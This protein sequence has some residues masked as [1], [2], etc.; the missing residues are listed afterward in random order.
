MSY[1]TL[2]ASGGDLIRGKATDGN[3]NS[4]LKVSNTAGEE[5]RFVQTPFNELLL[6]QV[7]SG[8]VV[9]S[10]TNLTS[11]NE[12]GTPQFGGVLI[13]DSTLA[14]E[15]SLGATA[16]GDFVVSKALPAPA[17]VVGAGG[18]QHGDAL[19]SDTTGAG[20]VVLAATALGDLTYTTTLP[21]PK[22]TVSF[23]AITDNAI[24]AIATLPVG[25]LVAT[26]VLTLGGAPVAQPVAVA[27]I[28][29]TSTVAVCVAQHIAAPNTANY[30]IGAITP[31]VGFSITPGG[32]TDVDEVRWFVYNT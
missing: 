10:T 7:S 2:L 19:I 13:Y 28:T 12:T 27:S 31:G 11:L 21:N 14:G 25:A 6:E 23:K 1:S 20:A 3:F 24:G 29:A 15:T 5:Q 26:G 16:T 22:P 4:G 30:T 9:L 17:G 18:I 32:A 8:G